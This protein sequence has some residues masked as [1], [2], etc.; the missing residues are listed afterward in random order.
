MKERNRVDGSDLSCPEY[1]DQDAMKAS[2]LLSDLMQRIYDGEK[3]PDLKINRNLIQVY[4]EGGDMT[5]AHL[6][7]RVRMRRAKNEFSKLE[8]YVVDKTKVTSER[9]D[10]ATE[11][12]LTK[13]ADPSTNTSDVGVV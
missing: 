2:N 10:Q 11:Y 13:H 12:W 7:D 4:M 6:D 9:I 8:R 1:H 3:I 5:D